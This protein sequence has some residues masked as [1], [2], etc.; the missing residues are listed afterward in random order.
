MGKWEEW[1]GLK[2]LP[3]KGFLNHGCGLGTMVNSVTIPQA[4]LKNLTDALGG[5]YH[6]YS[7]ESEVSLLQIAVPTPC[8]KVIPRGSGWCKCADYAMSLLFLLDLPCLSCSVTC[9]GK[10]S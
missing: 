3:R 2:A 6:C 5:H 7:P 1:D 10:K 4:I 9:I 8:P